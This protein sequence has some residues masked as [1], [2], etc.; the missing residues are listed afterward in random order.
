MHLK[1]LIEVIISLLDS[2]FFVGSGLKKVAEWEKEFHFFAETKKTKEVLEIRTFLI[3]ILLAVLWFEMV[4]TFS[5]KGNFSIG[6]KMTV[7]HNVYGY[8]LMHGRSE[9]SKVCPP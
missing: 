1:S 9:Q 7:E 4:V 5:A 2:A 6:Y 3:K 8:T